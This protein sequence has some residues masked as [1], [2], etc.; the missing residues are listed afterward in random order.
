MNR[1]TTGPPRTRRAAR[2][3]QTIR[4]TNVF[5][6]DAL[7]DADGG[8]LA[9]TADALRFDGRDGEQLAIPH[10]EITGVRVDV[11]AS[12]AGFRTIGN[13]FGL[14]AVLMAFVFVRALLSGAPLVSV[15]GVG[16]SASAILGC[17]GAIWFRRLE[18]GERTVLQVDHGEGSRTEFIARDDDG[19]FDRISE[20]VARNDAGSSSRVTARN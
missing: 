3:Q 15:V 8:E 13:A 14:A 9:C 2:D 12:V 19:A 20:R 5:E 11:D 18:V 6:G 17:Y 4:V 7:L 10:G 16:S 1:G